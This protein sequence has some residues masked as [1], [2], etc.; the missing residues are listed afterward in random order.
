[1]LLS[2][3]SDPQCK[4]YSKLLPS[5]TQV[6]PVV[7]MTGAIANL[8][9]FTLLALRY[10]S[11]ASHSSNFLD[12]P[13]FR[14]SRFWLLPSYPEAQGRCRGYS[15]LASLVYAFLLVFHNAGPPQAKSLNPKRVQSWQVFNQKSS[16]LSKHRKRDSFYLLAI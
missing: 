14:Q 10:N 3:S 2:L 9:M 11:Q 1:M 8:A 6:A 4:A 16:K 5:A 13:R 7:V 15:L 12:L